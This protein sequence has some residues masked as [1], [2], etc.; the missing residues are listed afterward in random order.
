MLEKDLFSVIP[1]EQ[2]QSSLGS[3]VITEQRPW[4]SKFPELVALQASSS[5]AFVSLED[6]FFL[7][8]Q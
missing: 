6:Y 1:L 2:S 4:A 8:T 7:L 5:K 3:I